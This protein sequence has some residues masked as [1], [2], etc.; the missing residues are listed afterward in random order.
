MHQEAQVA[1]GKH[2]WHINYYG[3]LGYGYQAREICCFC[4]KYKEDEHGPYNPNRQNPWSQSWPSSGGTTSGGFQPNYVGQ[5][6]TNFN[7]PRESQQEYFGVSGGLSSGTNPGGLGGRA[8]EAAAALG[9]AYARRAR[10][11]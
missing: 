3:A 2:C 7:N 1:C 9:A 5:T 10:E 6:L 8:S 11:D 4:G